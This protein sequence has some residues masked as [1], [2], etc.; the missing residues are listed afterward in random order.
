MRSPAPAR[1]TSLDELFANSA[2]ALR[3][4]SCQSH[5]D[6]AVMTMQRKMLSEKE[7]TAQFIQSIPT[8]LFHVHPQ[9]KG[10]AVY[11]KKL[12]RLFAGWDNRKAPIGGIV[13]F[14]L[15]PTRA[16]EEYGWEIGCVGVEIK[17]S[18]AVEKNAGKAITQIL[19][20]QSCLYSLPSGDTE[21]SMIFLFPYRYTAELIAS[22]MQQEG[23]GFVSANPSFEARFRLL[24]ANT[25]NEP[26]LTYYANGEVEIR[27]PRYGKKFGHR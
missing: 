23:L 8:D 6:Y 22:I 3:I 19:D 27:R 21:L 17:S 2:T 4:G 5:A 15:E 24:Q 20:Y 1:P 13:D 9:C 16:L 12:K 25:S 11:V 18:F 14:I 26:V 10:K 7:A